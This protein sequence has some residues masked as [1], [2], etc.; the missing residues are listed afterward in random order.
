M[1]IIGSGP[2]GLGVAIGL[3]ERGVGPVLILERW[4]KPGGVPAKYRTEPGSVPTYV[5]YTRG[6]ILFGQEFVDGLLEKLYRTDVELRLEST[7]ISVDKNERC[8]TVV[9]PERG[10]HVVEAEAIVL[11]TGARE[12]SA[13][14]RAWLAGDRRARVFQ[15]MQLLELLARD[16]EPRLQRPVVVGSDLIGY[17]VAAKLA[18]AGARE[19]QLVDV[20]RRPRTML[21]AR[22][23]FRR[24][25]RASWRSVGDMILESGRDGQMVKL[26]GGDEV[27]CD[28][29]FVTGQLVPN[30]ELLIP[31]GFAVKSP[32]N[33]PV[34]GTHGQLTA[35]GY[36]ATGNLLGGFRGGQW[37]Y[38]NG[39]RVAKAVRRYLHQSGRR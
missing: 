6:R 2:A 19:V 12:Q 7:V 8:I 1:A 5:T 29:V 25:V 33:V 3:A 21:P 34:T 16:K 26:D 4:D 11:A 32:T 13:S 35:A 18:V 37:C 30:S 31:A 14:E 20:T 27:P 28:A 39:L 23:Y 10:K 17:A 36:F 22:L 15:T 24:W 9:D 38:H